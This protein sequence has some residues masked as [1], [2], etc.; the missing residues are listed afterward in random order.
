MGIISPNDIAVVTAEM[1]MKT[2]AAWRLTGAPPGAL[3]CR[4]AVAIAQ[5]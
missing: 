1:K 2:N 5:R 3:G 4:G